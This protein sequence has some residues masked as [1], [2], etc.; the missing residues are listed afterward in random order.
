VPQCVHA[1]LFNFGAVLC[2]FFIPCAFA[3]EIYQTA[4]IFVLF[5]DSS[6]LSFSGILEER[7]CIITLE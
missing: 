4:F 5:L 3:A 7:F 6:W 2:A 1:K